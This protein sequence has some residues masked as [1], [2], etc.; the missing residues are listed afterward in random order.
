MLGRMIRPGLCSV[1]FR[2]LAPEELLHCAA[3]AGL[4]C[5]EWGGDIHVP[6]DGPDHAQEVAAQTKAAGLSVASYGSYFRARPEHSFPEVLTSAGA[7]GARRIRIWAGVLG[8]EQASP[9]DWRTVVRHT[10]EAADLAAAEDIELAFEF[11]GGTLADEP[12]TTLRLLSEVDRSNVS[13]YWQPPVG[14]PDEEALAGLEAL[15]PVLSCVHVFSW[16]PGKERLPLR[17]RED[18]WRGVFACLRDAGREVDALL[19]FV[20][21]DD[22]AILATEAAALLDLASANGSQH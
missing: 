10:R 14:A 7:L 9:D 1:T 16:W 15:L 22:P 20:P 21:G 2:E 17:A 18:L 12:A 4:R 5:V 3:D 8:S 11:H 13:C 19:E 6:P